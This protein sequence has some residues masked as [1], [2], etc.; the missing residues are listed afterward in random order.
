VRKGTEFGYTV[1]R[2]GLPKLRHQWSL[3][4]DGDGYG[5]Y[6]A[7]QAITRMQSAPLPGHLRMFI[8]SDRPLTHMTLRSGAPWAT[9]PVIEGEWDDVFPLFC[10]Y[11]RMGDA[12]WN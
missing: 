5:A 10:T 1:T 6:T 8:G 7:E 4:R 12:A 2:L 9:T 11:L 3:M